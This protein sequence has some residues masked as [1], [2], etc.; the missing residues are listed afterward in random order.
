AGLVLV[1]A[2]GVRIEVDVLSGVRAAPRGGKGIELLART[3]PVLERLAD[4][5]AD[6]GADLPA[7][8][9]VCTEERSG[10]DE[11]V[12]GNYEPRARVVVG[13]VGLVRQ[14]VAR[15]ELDEV[16]DLAAEVD[17]DRLRPGRDAPGL[18]LFALGELPVGTLQ[19][20]EGEVRPQ[21]EPPAADVRV[22]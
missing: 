4:R 2:P 18:D 12:R 17:R 1:V 7:R 22:R 16:L 13:V 6:V 20:G 19:G 8:A 14:V 15:L 3:S 10:M 5:I 9:V 21:V 11:R